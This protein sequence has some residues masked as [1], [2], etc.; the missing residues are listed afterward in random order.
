MPWT[1]SPHRPCRGCLHHCLVVRLLVIVAEEVQD[2]MYQ[3]DGKLLSDRVP[4]L[5]GLT[6]RLG[7]RDDDLS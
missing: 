6:A 7:V 4:G 2:A 1:H 3:Q 5:L